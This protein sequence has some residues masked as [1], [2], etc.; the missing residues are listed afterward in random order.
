MNKPILVLVPILFLALS[1][2]IVSHT[3]SFGVPVIRDPNLKLQLVYKG[4]DHATSMVIL[5]H[6]D[7]LVAEK[8]GK[9]LRI[10]GNNITGNP[11]LDISTVVNSTGERGLLAIEAL[12][13]KN[14]GKSADKKN[15]TQYIYLLFTEPSNNTL[16]DSAC[17]FK[18]CKV[19]VEYVNSVYRYI[20]TDGKLKNPK[21]MSQISLYSNNSINHI[22]GALA[23]DSNNRLFFTTGDGVDCEY[24]ENCTSET[25]I[26]KDK[27]SSQVR[28]GGIFFVPEDA[29]DYKNMRKNNFQ[30]YGYGIRNSF[31]LDFDPITGNLWDTENGPTFGDEIN[32]VKPGFNSGWPEIQ[33]VWQITNESDL[34]DTPDSGLSKGYYLS[35]NSHQNNVPETFDF[36]GKGKYSAPEFTWNDTVGVTSI[37][38]FNSDKLGKKYENNLFV[39]TF[40]G[41]I[42]HFK[43]DKNREQL[44][45][46]GQLKDKI[47]NND[48]ELNDALFAS[49]LTPIGVTDLEVGPDGYLYALS[50][51]S[52]GSIYKVTPK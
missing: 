41:N 46:D 14:I 3:F 22:G 52:H 17:F 40:N 45:L 23:I 13:H 20:F 49:G 6:G 15:N 7:I 34:K 2:L 19:K 33:G 51:G 36:H 28:A 9:V 8:Q 27:N 18:N 11:V 39:G 38:F 25:S 12:K 37:K 5:D 30:Q 1:W 48:D 26:G 32:L 21:L 43:M 10:V 24:L 47:A 4:L 50:F 16:N 42:Y 29:A 44:L 35:D 31:G